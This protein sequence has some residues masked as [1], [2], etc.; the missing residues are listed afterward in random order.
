MSLGLG[1]GQ[2][3][4]AWLNPIQRERRGRRPNEHHNPLEPFRAE[5]GLRYNPKVAKR[6]PRTL[7]DDQW[8]NVFAALRCHRDRALLALA[9]AV[10]MDL[11]LSTSGQQ[12]RSGGRP[13]VG[14][15]RRAVG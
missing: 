9:P 8:R 6:R 7:S 12:G 11:S 2:R 10:R 3:R 1:N 14:A 13:G 5:G 4:R 15:P